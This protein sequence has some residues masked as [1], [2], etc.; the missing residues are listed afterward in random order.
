MTELLQDPRP[1]DEKQ[2]ALAK[3]RHAAYACAPHQPSL[4][5]CSPPISPPSSLFPSH[6]PSHQEG[7]ERKGGRGREGGP[8]APM[9]T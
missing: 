4:Q 7:R 6:Q 3:V 2:T 9:P 8:P 5:V 1:L